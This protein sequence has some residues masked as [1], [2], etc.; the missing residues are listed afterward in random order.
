MGPGYI[1][2]IIILFILSMREEQI[3]A[4][5]TRASEIRDKMSMSRAAVKGKVELENFFNQTN[6]FYRLQCSSKVQVMLS[7]SMRLSQIYEI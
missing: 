7:L 6:V 5:S 2:I 3:V 1:C 4:G